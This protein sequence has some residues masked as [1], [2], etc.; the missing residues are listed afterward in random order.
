MDPSLQT[1][2]YTLEQSPPPVGPALF[3][4]AAPHPACAG[5]KEM[6]CYQPFFPAA[7]P[8]GAVADA[9]GVP[10]Q[11][12]AAAFVLVPKQV[13]EAQAA[14]ATALL[15]LAPGGV[16][17]A[18]AANDANGN[19]LLKWLEEKG[20]AGN[21][22]SKNKARCVIAVRPDM[23]PDLSDWIKDAAPRAM[24]FDG[25]M[26]QTRPGV[27]SWN[28]ADAGSRFL[29]RHL[30]V[31]IGGEVADF[32]CGIG[33]LSAHVLHKNIGPSALHMIDADARA[34]NLARMNVPKAVHYWADLARPVNGL[35]A[36]DAI[37]MN[38][39]FH[40]GKLTE[41]AL[42]QA[43]IRT[44]AHHLKKGGRLFMVANAHLP[45]EKTLEGFFARVQKNAEDGGFKVLT[46]VK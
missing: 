20:V 43:F 5:L 21:A 3:L 25:V 37:I 42:G 18:A 33:Y 17:Y 22:L 28:R 32:G 29:L 4:Y 27:F 6:D 44:A 36:L 11:K 9:D 12:Y 38:P 15:S 14:L 39:P 19:R 24:D 45:Y 16:L 1:L 10:E 30:P 34:L 41:A 8:L 35:P 23:L 7:Q 46:A 26:L 2:F 31:G 13:E 40:T